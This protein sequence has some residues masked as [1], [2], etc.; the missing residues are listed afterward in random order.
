VLGTDR[1][2]CS[3]AHLALLVQAGVH[4]VLRVGAR[5]M[6][7]FTPGRPFVMPGVRRT[8]AV[9]GIPRSRWLKALGVHD[10]LVTWFKPKTSPSW[11][12]KETLAALSEALVLR[13]D[14]YLDAAGIQRDAKGPLFR[15]INRW[16]QLTLNRMNRIDAFQMIKRRARDA[17][18]PSNTCCHTFRATG[19]TAYLENGGTLEK[20]QAIAAHQSPRTTK[21]YDRTGDDITL[22]EVEQIAISI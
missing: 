1:G 16:R 20:A 10:P 6:V 5:Q 21:P 9:K 3:Y 22:E 17:G 11:L 15:T 13:M 4:A 8:P 7:D 18:L 2:L 12:A 14:A 19:I